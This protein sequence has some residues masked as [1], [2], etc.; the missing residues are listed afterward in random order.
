VASIVYAHPYEVD[1]RLQRLGTKREEW[2]EVVKACVAA[3]GD[4]TDNDPQSPG[5]QMAWIFGTRM[6]RQLLRPRGLEKEILKGVECVTDRSRKIRFA[7]VS[8]DEGTCDQH[9]SPKNRTPKGPASELIT[10]L[11]NQYE[12][13]LVDATGSPLPYD[14]DGYSFWYLCVYD[15]GEDVRAELSSPI[16]FKS[17]YFVKFSER[18]FIIKPGE[19]DGINVRVP[20]K[21]TDPAIEIDIRRR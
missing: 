15:S 11:N 20:V 10:D 17:R 13:N 19:W 1:E 14:G 12:L 7:V 5:G 6:M 9:L 3:R 16:E 2:I 8:T 21:N 4:T 18:V